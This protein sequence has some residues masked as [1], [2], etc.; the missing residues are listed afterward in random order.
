MPGS[1][2]VVFDIV[3]FSPTRREPTDELLPVEAH[4]KLWLWL[5]HIC[6]R[7]FVFLALAAV[8]VLSFLKF[9]NMYRL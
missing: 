3:W 6:A 1:I 2:G 4:E 5:L 9:S 8:P 7:P